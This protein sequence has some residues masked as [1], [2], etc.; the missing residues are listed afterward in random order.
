LHQNKPTLGKRIKRLKNVPVGRV[1][2]GVRYAS[3]VDVGIGV[4]DL[5]TILGLVA[6]GSHGDTIIVGMVLAQPASL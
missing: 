5:R 6:N 3:G 4:P 2:P 1:V